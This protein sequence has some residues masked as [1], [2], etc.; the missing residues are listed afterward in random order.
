MLVVKKLLLLTSFS[1]F[2]YT[3]T[4]QSAIPVTNPNVAFYKSKQSQFASGET[5]FK[6]LKENLVS[7][8]EELVKTETEFYQ[9]GQQ[10]I[11][12]KLLT[13]TFAKNLTL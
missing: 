12:K 5:S 6:R 2:I 11:S 7:V 3:G 13:P 8:A 4:A 9:F 10:K 1:L